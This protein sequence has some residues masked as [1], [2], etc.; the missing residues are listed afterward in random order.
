MRVLCFALCL[1]A[2]YRFL[3]GLLPERVAA[4][5]T[6][7]YALDEA[8]C[9]PTSWL[10]NRSTLISTAIAL[11]ACASYVRARTEAPE[12]PAPPA[13]TFVWILLAFLSGEY[14]YFALGYIAAFELIGA[15]GASGARKR[16]LASPL[17]ALSLAALVSA[18]GALLGYGVAYSGYYISP[19]AD[20]VRFAYA[21][22]A[23]L[24]AL[25][26]D[27]VAGVPAGYVEMGSP[28]REILLERKIIDPIT[29]FNLP[30]YRSVAGVLAVLVLLGLYFGVRSLVRRDPPLASLR[31]LVLGACLA[32]LPAAGAVPSSRL[33]G[34]SAVG[35]AALIAVLVVRAFQLIRGQLDTAASPMRRI[36]AAV[37]LLAL[38]FVHGLLP[39]DRAYAEA[40]NATERS[41]I[42]R[43]W[44]LGADI[45]SE[46]PDDAQ[47]WITSASDFTT[48]AH[49]PW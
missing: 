2:A 18:G 40:R 28:L 15:D 9:A 20:P 16:S 27:I 38:V 6:L 11:V 22:V 21:A 37:V 45:P 36:G 17:I 13:R 35:F 7:V 42:A 26:I 43:N 39:A 47:V 10:A 1:W 30:S 41:R 25:L 19:F 33:T 23:R 32:L 5:A 44:V 49:V 34:G 14:G 12:R 46:L 29:W 8:H 3:S 31:F 4:V 24:P 48:A